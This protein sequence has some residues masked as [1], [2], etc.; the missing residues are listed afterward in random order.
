[1]AAH[2]RD[3]SLDRW[4][5]EGGQIRPTRTGASIDVE[6]GAVGNCRIPAS[7]GRAVFR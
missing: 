4:F 1:M 6:G 2:A 7:E 5:F 3:E